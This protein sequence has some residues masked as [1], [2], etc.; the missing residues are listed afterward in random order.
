MARRLANN[1]TVY[2][3]GAVELSECLSKP[4]QAAGFELNTKRIVK[5]V[6]GPK[7]NEVTVH[8][9]DGSTTKE[10]FLVRCSPNL[11]SGKHS[12]CSEFWLT[13]FGCLGPQA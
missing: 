11:F 2:T 8:L 5:L 10:G 1:V 13:Q 6:K 9:E 4:L 7:G 12:V 3:D